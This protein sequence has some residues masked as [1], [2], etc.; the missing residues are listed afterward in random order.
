MKK[1]IKSLAVMA[2]CILGVFAASSCSKD[3]FFG[4]EDSE[5]LN[6]STKTEIALSQEYTDYAIALFN[7]I[8]TMKQPVDTTD[9]KIQGVVNGKPVYYKQCSSS[10][11]E[12][13]E[14]LKKAYPI[15]E[16][17]DNIDFDD[18]QEI[19][20][21]NN[22]ALKDIAPKMDFS[23]KCSGYLSDAWVS[24]VSGYEDG[25][26]FDAYNT[27]D[28]AF[29]NVIWHCGESSYVC[30]GGLMFSDYSAA[31]MIGYSGY[32]PDVVNTATYAES[33]FVYMPSTDVYAL[34][35]WD[36]AWRLGPAYYNSSRLH[37]ICNE[38]YDCIS[39]F[40]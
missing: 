8:E 24:S 2:V 39:F 13:L 36:I 14:I 5:V 10:V 7:L 4:L 3:E 6:H 40:Y 34:E 28:G 33:D 32:W 37:Y 9:M 19:A 22:K 27:T 30:G 16:N 21:S 26:Y 18:I 11:K 23:T 38:E 29:S 1:E 17:A 15:L 20:L 12:S 35:V 31:S 25:W